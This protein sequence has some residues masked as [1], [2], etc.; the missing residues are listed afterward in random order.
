MHFG[1]FRY[2]NNPNFRILLP[3]FVFPFRRL[4]VLSVLILSLVKLIFTNLETGLQ[5]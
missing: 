5:P 4:V 3:V 1:P 2:E